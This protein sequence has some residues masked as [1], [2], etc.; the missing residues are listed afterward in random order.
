MQRSDFWT[1]FE[2]LPIGAYRSSAEGRQLRANAALVR[3]NGYDTEA[4][5]LAAVNDIAQEWYVD[6]RQRRR[7]RDLIERNGQV[8]DFCS[9][10][11]RHKTRERIWIRENAHAVRD[12]GGALLYFEGTVEDVTES[13]RAQN[14]LQA[15]ERRFRAL[16][17]KAQ[18]LT[19][20]CNAHG[21]VM[22]ASQAAAAMLGREPAALLG[23]NVFDW[24]HPDDLPGARRDHNAVLGRANPGVESIH[25]YRHADGSW[26]Y[27]ASLASNCLADDAV[28]GIVLNFRDATERKRAEQAESA[29]RENDARWKLALES[30][31]DGVWDWYVQTGVEIYSKRFKEMYGY[32]EHELSGQTGEFDDRTHPDDRAQRDRDRQAHLDGL[33]PTYINE[34]RVR[35]RDGSWKWILSRGTVINRDADGRPIR[36]IGTHTDVGSR[37]A[38][39]AALRELNAQLTEKTGQLQT[40]LGSIGQGIFMIGAD[41]RVGTYNSRVCELL[42]LPESLLAARPTLPELTRF[43][44]ERGDF[45]PDS[46]W[47][48]VHARGYVASAAHNTA[49]VLPMHYLRTTRAGR[50]LEVK[51]QSLPGGAMVRTFAD[52]TDYVVAERARR[53]LNMLLEATQAMA[54]VGGWEVDVVNDQVFWTDEVYRILETS[55]QEYT[56]TTATTMQFFTPESARKISA[57]IEDAVQRGKPHDLELEMVTARG[58]NIWVHSASMVTRE[59]G[60]VVKRTSVIQDITERRLA[61]ALARES[62]ERWKLALDST[63]DGVWDWYVQTGVEKFSR[64]CKEM[65]GYAEHEMSDRAEDFD[66]R[67]HPEDVGQLLKDRQAHLDGH[68]PI[69]VNEHRMR[70]KDGSWK[71]VLSRGMVISRDEQGRALRM[72][73]THTDIT[74][75]KKSEALVWQ[76]A[77]F[78]SLTGL[79]NRRMLRDRLEQE[80]KKSDRDGLQLAILFIDLDH[81]KEVNDTLGHDAGDL[82]LIEAARRIRRCVRDS[83]TVARMGGDEF[84]LVVSELHNGERLERI[85]DTVLAAMSS[86]F[87]LGTEQVYVSAS[88]GI[89]MYP[90]DATE[91]ENLFKNADQALYVAKGA[92]RNRFSFFTPALQE[93]AQTRVRLANDLRTGLS[94]QQF[95]V[96]YQPIVDLADGAVHKAEALIRWQHPTRGLVSPADFIPIAES[97][98]L[99][100]EIGEWVFRQ[101]AAQAQAWRERHHAQFQIS[102]NKSPVQFHNDAGRQQSWVAHLRQIGL[103]GDAVVVEIT[104]GLLLDTSAAV[105]EQLLQL[106]DAGIQVSLDDFGTGYSSLTYLQ[107]FDIDYIK[108]DQSFVRHLIPECTELALCKAIIVMAHELGMKVIAEG[109]E[110]AGQRDLLVAAGCDYGQGYLFARPMPV[111]AFDAFMAARVGAVSA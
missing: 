102:V 52:V 76:Q 105:T 106:R 64:R 86:L 23:G 18:V 4:E 84:T 75:R 54:H 20:V 15:S 99:I 27:L 110:T 35:C 32:G 109:V 81:F 77:N 96:V 68:T 43:Q 62:E 45:G 70:C 60:Q 28:L 7:F 19:V 78:D 49:A 16:T 21:G 63:G 3:L 95:R 107:R 9:E 85:L 89:T 98:G 71:W 26:R 40:T 5:L 91:V 59:H 90:S 72:I 33:T 101:A 39:E 22:Y 104:E 36:M 13:R 88:I 87:Q 8:V 97:S 12:E 10:I 14:A 25:R 61:A 38:A 30:A 1:L 37:K 53:R 65:Y 42:D 73:G 6:P 66:R 17:E 83:D 57:A 92:G 56:P 100:V 103:G 11:Y 74:S 67:T 58:R 111:D 69:Y 82:L 29:L 55:P 51:T 108:I 34:H 93:A 48:D 31:G 44:F 80:I 46:Q 50:T 2:L 94:E 41:G 24:I 79:P 47:V